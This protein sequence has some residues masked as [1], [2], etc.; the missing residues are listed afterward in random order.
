MHSSLYYNSNTN[1]ITMADGDKLYLKVKQGYRRAHKL[2]RQEKVDEQQYSVVAINSLKKQV[3]KLDDGI[4]E[5]IK[6]LGTSIEANLSKYIDN[7]YEPENYLEY[8][9]RDPKVNISP[10]TIGYLRQSVQ[11]ICH[12]IENNIYS[13]NSLR[14]PENLIEN[15]IFANYTGNFRD[16]A[17]MVEERFKYSDKKT[18]CNKFSKLDI[19]V[20]KFAKKWSKNILRSN[21]FQNIQ[22]TKRSSIVSVSLDEDLL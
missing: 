12:D 7:E 13:S 1:R 3:Q 15:L 14:I 18:I 22:G 11:K 4:V 21:S 10:I 9:C 5:I 20:K 19:E 8:L 17:L 16:L 2:I 6:R